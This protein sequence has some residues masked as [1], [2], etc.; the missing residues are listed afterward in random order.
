ME[1]IRIKRAGFMLSQHKEEM[2]PGSRRKRTI[3]TE[4]AQARVISPRLAIYKY[5]T[6]GGYSRYHVIHIPTGLVIADVE[7][8]DIGLVKRS[9]ESHNWTLRDDN[10]FVLLYEPFTWEMECLIRYEVINDD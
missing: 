5:F 9:F 4:E 8:G 7:Y 6:D 2:W 3:E 10:K 1:H